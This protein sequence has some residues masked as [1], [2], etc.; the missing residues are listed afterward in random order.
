MKP[1]SL[2]RIA[3]RLPSEAEEAVLELF[4]RTFEKPASSY[5]DLETGISTVSVYF[6]ER[7]DF[8]QA[9]RARLADG[10]ERIRDCNLGIGNPKVSLTKLPPQDWAESWKRHF[11]PI[12]IGSRLL[13]KPSWSKRRAKKG[14]ATIV[15]DPGLSFGTGQHPTTEFCLRELARRAK[16]GTNQAFLDI[17]T[18]SGI[19]AIAA[20]RLR[21]GPIDAFDFDPDAVRIARANARANRVLN[22]VHFFE[23]DVTKLSR[24]GSKYS[25]ICANLISNLLIDLSDRILAR[26]RESGMLVVAGILRQEF[27]EVQRAYEKVGLELIKCEVQKEWRSG[28]FAR[29]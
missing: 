11:Q 2:W 3:V 4:Q 6:E 8:T 22:K 25:L 7:P 29:R 20:A 14:Q 5:A 21:Y 23:Q 9:I 16:P 18:G 26:L 19:L 17:G 24:R 15:L 12:E 28:T 1:K 10:L 27:E 13:I